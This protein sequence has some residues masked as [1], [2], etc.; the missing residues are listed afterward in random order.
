[1]VFARWTLFR[2]LMSVR[3]AVRRC[4]TRSGGLEGP[5]ERCGD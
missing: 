1:M 5:K 4:F 3:D 2:N